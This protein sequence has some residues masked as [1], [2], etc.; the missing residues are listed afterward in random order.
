L[1]DWFAETALNSS[2]PWTDIPGDI[3]TIFRHEINNRLI[4]ILGNAELVLAHADRLSPTDT[5]R[6][7]TVVDLSVRL[8]ETVRRL[9]NVLERQLSSAKSA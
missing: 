3:E 4:G 8:R 5:Q 9:G 2:R 7:Q 1:C 6:L